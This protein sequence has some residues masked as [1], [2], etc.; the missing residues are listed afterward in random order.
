MLGFVIAASLIAP[1]KVSPSLHALSA[2]SVAVAPDAAFEADMTELRTIGKTYQMAWELADQ[3]PDDFVALVR[4]YKSAVTRMQTIYGKYKSDIDANND[5]GKTVKSAGKNA[6]IGF[7]AFM[8]LAGDFA[9]AYPERYKM[10]IDNAKESAKQAVEFKT[11]GY[12]RASLT[13]L[14]WAEWMVTIL[15]AF[16]GDKDPTALAC[17]KEINALKADYTAKEAAMRKA[18]ARV[19]KDPVE[20]Y[21][22]GDKEALRKG[23]LAAWTKAYPNDKVIKVVFDQAAWKQN[24]RSRW[25]DAT[26][27]WHHINKSF[28]ELSVVVQKDAKTAQI[29]AAFVNKENAS[30]AISYGVDTKG[31]HFVVDELELS[32]IKK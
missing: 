24:R 18:T 5:R 8:D 29:F 25:N 10:R 11:P 15:V 31:S 28:L 3:K 12:Y 9:K 16:N 23:V 27:E 19:V 30:G 17:S 4:D 21:N 13:Q 20:V 6:T 2:A 32:K 14:E 22:G 26:S 7:Q 1:P